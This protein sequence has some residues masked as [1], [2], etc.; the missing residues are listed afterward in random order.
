MK[1]GSTI[2]LAVQLQSN[3]HF[4][5]S[6]TIIP[7]R[8]RVRR[9]ALLTVND[10]ITLDVFLDDDDTASGKIYLDDGQ[11]FN[12]RNG[13]YLSGSFNYQKKT[14]QY[15]AEHNQFDSQAWL[16]RIKVFNYPAKPSKVSAVKGEVEHKLTFSYET[17][18]KVLVVRKPALSFKEDWEIRI[19]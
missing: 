18:T 8:E 11:T 2:L 19:A 4:Q 6:G 13:E 9:S 17:A 14:L 10:P 7:K 16:E 1:G 5:R 3:P 12:Y 15:K